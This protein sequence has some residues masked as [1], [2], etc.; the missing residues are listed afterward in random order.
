VRAESQP[1]N[2][3]KWSF[4]LTDVDNSSE[5]K[6]SID[7]IANLFKPA[8][9]LPVEKK[10]AQKKRDQD[11]LN[12]ESS[13][14]GRQEVDTAAEAN[15][16]SNRPTDSEPGGDTLRPG[17]ARLIA[18][19]D[20]PLP[21][22]TI[23]PAASQSGRGATLVVTHLEMPPLAKP[24]PDANCRRDIITGQEERRLQKEILEESGQ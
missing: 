24:K 7:R 12:V 13:K 22:I 2:E 3:S 10:L 6:F 21:G 5:P 18:L 20:E 14:D 15:A 9:L 16:K 11:S 23:D 1:A 17:E 19:I 8:E 4:S